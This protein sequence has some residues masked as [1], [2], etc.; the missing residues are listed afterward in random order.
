MEEASKQVIINFNDNVSSNVHRL[1][2]SLTSVGSTL[3]TCKFVLEYSEK[4]RLASALS[5]EIEE[6]FNNYFEGRLS[7]SN[8]LLSTGTNNERID[9][10]TKM[11]SIEEDLRL[12]KSI[13]CPAVHVSAVCAI[14]F[15]M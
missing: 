7:Q 13:V 4:V 14:N 9:V 6:E 12:V 15:A 11:S 2:P 1:F 5:N 3:T 10:S 8:D